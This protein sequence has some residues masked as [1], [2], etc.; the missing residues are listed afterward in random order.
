MSL[1]QLFTSRKP[2]VASTFVAGKGKLFYDEATGQM[3]LG[4]GV[5]PGGN[6]IPFTIASTT[7]VGGVKLGPGVILNNDNQIIIDPAGLDFAFGDFQATIAGSGAATLSAINDN[8]S[9]DIVTSGTAVI[10]MVGDFHVHRSADYDPN[11]FDIDGA[12]FAV[13]ADGQIQMKVPLSDSTAGALEIIGNDTGLFVSPNQTGVILHVTGNSGLPSRNYF[14]ANQNYVLLA[15]RRYNGTQLNPV[16]VLANDIMLRVVAQGATAPDNSTSAT[17]QTFGPARI[18]FVATENQTATTQGGEV[19]IYSTANGS[20]ATSTATLVA[21]FNATTGVTASKFVG[22]LQTAAQP[23]ITSVGTLTS[24]T[25]SGNINGNL[26]GTTVTA[27]SFVGTIITPAQP[28][29]TSIG[30]LTNLSVTGTITGGVFNGKTTRNIR[31]AGTIADAGTVTIDFLTDDIVLFVWGNGV[32]LAY[33]NYTAGRIV[34]VI[35]RKAAGTG[36][37]TLS[38]GGVTAANVSSGVTNFS[39]SQDTTYFIELT[40]VNTTIGS[41]Y[42][43][44]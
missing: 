31:D 8:Q 35:A 44:L 1:Q 42:V 17:F 3:R 11:T 2:Y 6:L 7:T 22:T 21:T 9:I 5:T 25:V 23:N 40:C 34:K 28:N 10:N 16:R 24:L 12:V 43:K 30:T 4:N 41:V 37:D 14:D 32:S 36:N 13:K 26:S 38:L 19:R 29:I 15:G 20:S 33:S 18:D 39:G 27:N